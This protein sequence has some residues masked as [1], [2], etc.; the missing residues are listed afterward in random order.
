MKNDI[1]T[2]SHFN[3]IHT[4]EF[5]SPEERCNL[6]SSRKVHGRHGNILNNMV[7]A[8]IKATKSYSFLANNLGFLRQDCHNFLR[9][10]RKEIIEAG[11]GQSIINHFKKR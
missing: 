3:D 5:A 6:R 11:D 8:G 7:G 9:T 2:V 10:V 1:W 4:H